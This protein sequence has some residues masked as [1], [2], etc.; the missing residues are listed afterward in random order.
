MSP[1]DV[2]AIA[3]TAAR[4]WHGDESQSRPIK[5]VTAEFKAG[6]RQGYRRFF[7][8]A[9]DLG[10]YGHDSDYTCIDLLTEI[11]DA[12]TRGDCQLIVDQFNPEFLER[13]LQ[14]LFDVFAS[15]RIELFNCQVQSGS[16]RILKLMGREYTSEGW[17]Q[18]M[19][20]INKKFPELR[21]GTHLMVGFPSETDKTSERR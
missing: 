18:A 19:L 8:C 17:R 13:Y 3:H 20:T 4:S 5:E 11:L 10:S 9:E 14:P 12:D 15:G 2:L 7:L 21:L 6:I 1:K 16:D